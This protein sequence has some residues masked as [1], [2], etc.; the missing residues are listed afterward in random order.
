MP[1]LF[2]SLPASARV[3]ES[4]L[5]RLRLGVVHLLGGQAGQDQKTGLGE[6]GATLG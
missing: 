4:S 3:G 2:C 5:S 6:L 1:E